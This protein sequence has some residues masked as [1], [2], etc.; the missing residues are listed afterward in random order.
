MAKRK[1][2]LKRF[3]YKTEHS[4][5]G[6]PLHLVDTDQVRRSSDRRWMLCEET[7]QRL[8]CFSHTR[9]KSTSPGM[10][11]PFDPSSILSDPTR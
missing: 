9:H 10:T 1:E 5:V 3:S 2:G 7:T 6:E 4:L 8:F 11:P